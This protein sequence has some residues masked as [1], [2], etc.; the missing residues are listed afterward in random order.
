MNV[1]D[2]IENKSKSLAKS[3]GVGEEQ[4]DIEIYEYA[5]F[6]ILSQI[7]T[8]GVGLI[9]AAIFNIFIPYLICTLCYMTLRIFAGGYHCK[10]FRQCFYTSN[11][12]YLFLTIL[13]IIPQNSMFLLIL[14][15]I[16]GTAITP[17]CPKPS[18][19]SL[20]R[21]A[22]KDKKFRN[23]YIISLIIFIIIASLLIYLNLNTYAN[24]ICYAILGTGFVV[25]DIGECILTS[26]WRL[27]ENE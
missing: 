5:I 4:E 16:G 22:I 11:A 24:A 26:F 13:S 2:Y 15:F 14:A 6:A 12:L 7:L 20:S 23:K 1:F 18:E 21:G 27:V 19:Y 8:N 9:L 10:T 3:I 25:S 17:Y